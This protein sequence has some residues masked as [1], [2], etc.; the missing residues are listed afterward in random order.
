MIDK[1]IAE[2]IL[3]YIKRNAQI[4]YYYVLNGIPVALYGKMYRSKGAATSNV[5]AF[6]I[7]LVSEVQDYEKW[8]NGIF[9]DKWDEE[10]YENSK[11]IYGDNTF[12]KLRDYLRDTGYD[13]SITSNTQWVEKRKQDKIWGKKLSDEL[14]RNGTLVLKEME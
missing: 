8:A 2:E 3:P 7:Q 14:V 5:R 1:E 10:R 4:H 13:F 11:K 6:F 12:E 9:N